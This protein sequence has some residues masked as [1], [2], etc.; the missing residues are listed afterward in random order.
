MDIYKVDVKIK[1]GLKALKFPGWAS[2]KFKGIHPNFA[3]IKSP[4]PYLEY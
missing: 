1:S 4:V 3:L 2:R